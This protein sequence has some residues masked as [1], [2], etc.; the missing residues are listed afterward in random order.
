MKEIPVLLHNWSEVYAKTFQFFA[1]QCRLLTTL[2]N[3]LETAFSSFPTVFSTLSKREIVI[4]V[5]FNLSS[6]DAFNL[7][8][9][10]ILLFG[11]GLSHFPPIQRH[12]H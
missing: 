6:A 12:P 5:T 11:K 7:V 10:K 8:M 2:R 1:T 4:L 3:A 9:S